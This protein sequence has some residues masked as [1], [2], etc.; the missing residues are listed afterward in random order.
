MTDFND[1]LRKPTSIVAIG[2][3]NR[4]RT[5]MHYVA[6]H[7]DE[8]RLVAVVEPDPIRR[9]AMADQFGLP[10]EC[11]FE[12]YHDYF[13]NPI[14]AD[15]AFICTPEREHFEPCMEALRL[16]MHVLLEKPVAQ[17]YEQCKLIS[18][19]AHQVGKIVCVCH[20]L[21]Y[22]PAFI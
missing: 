14:K 9:N 4:M 7:P 1:S 5:Y 13:E 6:S 12:N 15:V 21:R 8:A 20:V 17:N 18:K 3:G 22:H 16:N 2:V 19:A 11:R 10:E